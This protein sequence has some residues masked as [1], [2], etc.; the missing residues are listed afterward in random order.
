MLRCDS[1]RGTLRSCGLILALYLV[2]ESRLVRMKHRLAGF[3][4]MAPSTFPMYARRVNSQG[5]VRS[6]ARAPSYSF[7]FVKRGNSLESW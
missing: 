1:T 2:R 7:P 6:A 5:W 4:G 3:A